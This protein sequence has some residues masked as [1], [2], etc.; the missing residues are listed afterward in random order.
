MTVAKAEE[1]YFIEIVDA[2][3]PLVERVLNFAHPAPPLAAAPDPPIEPPPTP[4]PVTLT[5]AADQTAKLRLD[6]RAEIEA[7]IAHKRRRKVSGPAVI[8]PPPGPSPVTP[9]TRH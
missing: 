7:A 6:T 9:P 4:P 8:T 3:P 5:P 2:P 1:L